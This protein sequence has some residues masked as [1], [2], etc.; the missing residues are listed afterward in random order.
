MTSA[1]AALGCTLLEDG[2]LR[3]VADDGA[4]PQVR[5]WL[6][7]LPLDRGVRPDAAGAVIQVAVRAAPPAP[8]PGRPTLALDPVDAWIAEPGER[9]T[10]LS[11]DRGVAGEIDLAGLKATIGVTPHAARPI[12][13]PEEPRNAAVFSALTAAAA[14]LLNRM[15]RALLH[16]AAVVAPDGGAWLLVGSAFAGKT[17][18][19]VNL[20][21]GGWDYISDDHV[22]L[23]RAPDGAVVVEGWPRAFHLDRGYADGVSLGDRDAVDPAGFGPGG[24]RRS[25]RLAG[26]LFPRV[27][28]A[29][30]TA[31]A[32]VSAADALTL[33]IRQSPWLLADRAV[34]RDVLALLA[35]T[36]SGAAFGLSL[37]RDSYRDPA[38]LLDA[39]SLAV[40]SA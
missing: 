9:V 33:L 16:A 39:L 27:V 34:A 18:T 37:G 1:T 30:P 36:V 2:S 28:A 19:T 38:R 35:D 32:P 20:I 21:R 15:R 29:Q 40:A 13:A 3:V 22:V 11:R 5:H 7:R 14:L 26:V 17:T 10:L 23:G 6:P 12:A 8:P 31:A 4:A 24:W 25:A